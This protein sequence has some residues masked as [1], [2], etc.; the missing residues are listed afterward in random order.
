MPSPIVVRPNPK[1]SKFR[2]T[3]FG[4]LVAIAEASPQTLSELQTPEARDRYSFCMTKSLDFE[5]ESAP[6]SSKQIVDKRGRPI[7]NDDF[8]EK[9]GLAQLSQ[10]NKTQ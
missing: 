3:E 6:S 2:D 4:T 7:S 1:Y 9:D 8:V 10:T 5:S